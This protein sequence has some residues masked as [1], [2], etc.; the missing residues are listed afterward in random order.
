MTTTLD[1]PAL[2]SIYE[3]LLKIIENAGDLAMSGFNNATKKI[4]TKTDFSDL[5]TYYDKAIETLLIEGIRE[6]YPN[7]KCV[8]I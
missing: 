2:D 8:I 6:E 7:H 1:T 5:V 4:D 3:L